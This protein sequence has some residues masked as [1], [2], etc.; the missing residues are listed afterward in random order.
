MRLYFNYKIKKLFKELEES[1][2]DIGCWAYSLEQLCQGKKYSHLIYALER[3]THWEGKATRMVDDNYDKW[4]RC[5]H[6]KLKMSKGGIYVL[7]Y[8]FLEGDSG[9]ISVSAVVDKK[10]TQA[11]LLTEDKDE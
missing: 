1:Y 6:Y 4:E 10:V 11:R 9:K 8:V 5:R 7:M 3:L 2:P